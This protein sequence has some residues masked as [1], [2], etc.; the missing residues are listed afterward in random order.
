M[1][2][3]LLLLTPLLLFSKAVKVDEILTEQNKLKLDISLSYSNINKKR[4]ITAPIN[5]EI[6]I[7]SW[8]RFGYSRSGGFNTYSL[9]WGS[10][11]HYRQNIGSSTLRRWNERLHNFRFSSRWWRTRDTGHFHLRRY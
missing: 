3:L 4:E 9:R 1:R 7:R 11:R 5:Y 10:N 6:S 8:V 2:N